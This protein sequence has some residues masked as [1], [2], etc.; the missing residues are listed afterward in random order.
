M[1]PISTRSVGSTRP[2]TLGWASWCVACASKAGRPRTLRIACLTL[3]TLAEAGD[4][5]AQD[6]ALGHIIDGLRALG[7]DTVVID[8]AAAASS[9]RAPPRRCLLSHAA[10]TPLRQDLLGRATWQIR[11]RAG[12]DV[13]LRLPLAAAAMAVGA[14]NTPR[15]FAEMLRYARERRRGDRDPRSDG[16]HACRRQRPGRSS[17]LGAPRS[18]PQDLAAGAGSAWRLIARRPA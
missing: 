1:P 18:I 12:V 17:A 3:D 4:A 11:T 5:A 7:A 8:A 6:K 15:L 10:P 16:L 13:F 2:T 9:A 14:A